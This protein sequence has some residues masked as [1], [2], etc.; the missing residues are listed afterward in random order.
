[1]NHSLVEFS[2][3][4]QDMI[5][6]R[7]RRE[8]HD[9]TAL[10]Q[11]GARALLNPD[12]FDLLGEILDPRVSPAEGLSRPGCLIEFVSSLSGPLG[13][14]SLEYSDFNEGLPESRLYP[15]VRVKAYSIRGDGRVKAAIR[16]EDHEQS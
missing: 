9:G 8:V 12:L 15:P 4:G 6:Y 11:L 14:L 2:L 16:G 10:Y 5:L 3:I 13:T 7:P 1:M